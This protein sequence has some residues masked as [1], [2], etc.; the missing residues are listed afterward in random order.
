M[1]LK[2]MATS[3]KLQH[4]ISEIILI[5]LFFA[6][7]KVYKI[8]IFHVQHSLTVREIKHFNN[9]VREMGSKW[10]LEKS[11]RKNILLTL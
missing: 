7:G 3:G 10:G 6:F 1:T 4:E 11:Y 8:D 2:I 5:S 9:L